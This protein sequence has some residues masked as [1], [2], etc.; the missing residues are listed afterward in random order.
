[1]YYLCCFVQ[2]QLNSSKIFSLSSSESLVIS[3]SALRIIEQI[4][5]WS[6][7]FFQTPLLV[8]IFQMGIYIKSLHAN[9]SLSKKVLIFFR[10]KKFH[11]NF[12]TAV[13]AF[14]Q[15]RALKCTQYKNISKKFCDSSTYIASRP[16]CTMQKTTTVDN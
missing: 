7:R 15:K 16:S 14:F 8:M 1:M 2:Q 5:Q 12:S 6:P 11:V 9:S 10:K 3:G 4:S 13:V